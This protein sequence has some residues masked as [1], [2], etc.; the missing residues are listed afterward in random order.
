MQSEAYNYLIHW[1]P[2]NQEIRGFYKLN[3]IYNE[4][5]MVWK[6]LFAHH[7]T[8]DYEN[9]D[10]FKTCFYLHFKPMWLQGLDFCGEIE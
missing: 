1:N 10:L 4:Y 9:L 2:V 8:F 7:K 5:G 6:E 3:N